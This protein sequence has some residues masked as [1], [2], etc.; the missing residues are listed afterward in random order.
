M[1]KWRRWLS[2]LWEHFCLLFL[3]SVVESIVTRVL[4]IPMSRHLLPSS[5]FVTSLCLVP[6]Q[7]WKL[8]SRVSTP[9]RTQLSWV[10]FLFICGS[11]HCNPGPG[12]KYPCSECDKGPTSMVF[13]AKFVS[14]GPKK[15]VLAWLRLNISTGARLMTAGFVANVP[16]KHCPFM[17]PLYQ[18]ASV[19]L[20]R[21]PLFLSPLHSSIS[22]PDS[23]PSS[24]FY[25]NARRW[26]SFVPYVFHTS[27]ILL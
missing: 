12:P 3:S 25:F 16:S 23:F 20:S 15:S 11:V 1:Q 14:A 24:I 13:T 27:M 8:R 7:C 21:H 10:L 6:H 19:A 9:T 5:C 26:M 22:I 17:M 4:E 2:V 18:P